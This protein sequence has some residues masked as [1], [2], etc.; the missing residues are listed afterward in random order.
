MA[1]RSRPG[2]TLDL[3]PVA[4]GAGLVENGG[5][6]PRRLLT[7]GAHEHGSWSALQA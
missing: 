7:I 1:I 5:L 4:L 2:L 3:F 6:G